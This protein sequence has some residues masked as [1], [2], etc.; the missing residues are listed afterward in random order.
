[1]LKFLFPLLFLLPAFVC[2]QDRWVGDDKVWHFGGSVFIG[3]LAYTAVESKP[4]AFGIAMGV[5][6]LKEM[7]DRKTTGFSY[8]DLV[9]DAAGAYLG[10][11]VGAWMM[12][13]QRGGVVVSYR[14]EF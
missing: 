9:W 5:G 14:M 2:A 12:Q 11:Q 1:M 10:V 8:K 6:L 4:I 3:T 13:A 7:S